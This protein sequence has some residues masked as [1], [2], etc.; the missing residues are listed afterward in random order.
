MLNPI[1]PDWLLVIL[2]TIVL[3]L[4][5][6]RV[7][8]RAARMHAAESALLAEASSD[9]F[10]APAPSSAKPGHKS[11]FQAVKVHILLKVLADGHACMH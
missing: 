1:V 9:S 8:F 3:L 10:M 11:P 4:L 5:A 2:L 7:T 6:A